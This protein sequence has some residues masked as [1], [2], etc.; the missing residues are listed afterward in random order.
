M[1]NSEILNIFEKRDFKKLQK[2]EQ[3]LEKEFILTYAKYLFLNKN[4]ITDEEY[5]DDA[6][7]FVAGFPAFDKKTVF[8]G[9]RKQE[10]SSYENV[11][12]QVFDNLAKRIRAH[13]YSADK[14]LLY[15]AFGGK[16]LIDH[17]REE[18]P[19]IARKE[20]NQLKFQAM[21]K[22]DMK[23]KIGHSPNFI[24]SWTLREYIELYYQKKKITKRKGAWML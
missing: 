5:F 24:D 11:R 4:S 13:G 18:Y 8:I 7:N 10:V 17:L 21:A 16:M 1:S 12:G 22:K 9:G 6:V 2:F 15:R 23:V 19:V 3:K 20:S 14:M